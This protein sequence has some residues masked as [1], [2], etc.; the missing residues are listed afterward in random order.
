METKDAVMLYICLGIMLL[1]L[2]VI[3]IVI[4]KH[5]AIMYGLIACGCFTL[6]WYWW[7]FD[8]YSY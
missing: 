6:A 3:N 5:I 1:I 7:R 4:H 8:Q 2:F